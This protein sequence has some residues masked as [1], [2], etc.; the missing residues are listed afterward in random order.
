MSSLS[1]FPAYFSKYR[2]TFYP[3]CSRCHFSPFKNPFTGLK[4]NCTEIFLYFILSLI[5]LS[6]KSFIETNLLVLFCLYI[7]Y[8]SIYVIYLWYLMSAGPIICIF[9]FWIMLSI[10]L[11][12]A[13]D[14]FCTSSCPSDVISKTSIFQ[15]RVDNAAFSDTLSPYRRMPHLACSFAVWIAK[16]SGSY[17]CIMAFP[18]YLPLPARPIARV[19]IWKVLCCPVI[20]FI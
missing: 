12:T 5:D 20:V 1:N 2:V 13:S 10:S 6:T 18:G 4:S 15:D 14:L 19:S 16:C 17:V 8:F 3:Y 7:Y 11:A 9:H